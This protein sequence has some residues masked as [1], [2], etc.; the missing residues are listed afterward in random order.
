[1][2]VEVAHN[3]MRLVAEG[4]EDEE[5][6][7][8]LRANA[9]ASYVALLDKPHLP[10]ALVSI[11]CWVRSAARLVSVAD[12]QG[13]QSTRV[14]R[15]RGA[16]VQ[17]RGHNAVYYPERYF[18]GCNMAPKANMYIYMSGFHTGICSGGGGGGE[19]YEW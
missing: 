19:L 9:M 8:E 12:C 4:T 5:M 2:R 17:P 1:M 6:D 13:G 18:V 3:L 16:G 14:D 15:A 11:I 10:D 7:R